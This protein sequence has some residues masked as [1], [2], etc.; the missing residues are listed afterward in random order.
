[1]QHGW[2]R[3]L[4]AARV[5]QQPKSQTVD[6]ELNY[7]P[8]G[9]L[10]QPKAGKIVP[11]SDIVRRSSNATAVDMSPSNLDAKTR[12]VVPDAT[13]PDGSEVCVLCA[14]ARGSMALFT[15]MPGAVSKPVAHRT[16]EEIWYIIRG[17]G[18]MWRKSAD[19]E[20]I[21][22]LAAGVSVTLPSGTRFQFRCDGGEPLEAV[23]VTMPSWPGADEA[24]PV[25]GIWPATL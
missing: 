24:Y 22:E 6:A 25:E 16:V 18:R 13:A 17:K 3:R 2:R 1:M 23:A 10:K 12:A 8:A 19:S 21:A 9:T 11:G 20:D 4:R 15:L 7:G 14:T 5:R